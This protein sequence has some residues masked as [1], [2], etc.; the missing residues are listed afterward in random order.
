MKRTITLFTGQWADLSFENI[1]QKAKSFG[2]KG[3]EIATWGDHFDVGQA[4]EE[5]CQQK[6]EI[7]TKYDLK[8]FAMSNHLVG[9]AVCDNIDERHKCILPASVW[10]DGEPEGVRQ[11][12]AEMM[13]KTADA[14]VMM[15][16]DT[17]TGFTGSSI[18]HLLYSFPPVTP[19]MIENGFKDFANRWRPILDYFQNVGV[20]FAL[21]VHPTEIAFDIASTRRALNAIGNHPSFGLIMTPHT[22]LIK[23][24]ITLL[25][26]QSLPI[27]FTTYI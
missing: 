23:E 16:V 6:L 4:T 9:Q 14:A 5:Y 24:W 18:W 12:A 8:V 27:E 2:Y 19:N 13:K 26:F 20:R 17:I 15:G 3:L 25:L 21:E 10:G 1:C 7:L 11:R 22:S